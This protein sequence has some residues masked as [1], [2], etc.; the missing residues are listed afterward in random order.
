MSFIGCD[1]KRF[2][3]QLQERNIGLKGLYFRGKWRRELFVNTVAI[4]GSRR[5]TDY[6]RI[7]IGRLV[8]VLVEAGVTIISGFMYGV[9]REAH[10]VCLRCGGRTIAVLGWG[11]D[12]RVTDKE[13]RIYQDIIDKGGLVVSEYPGMTSAAIWTFPA[14][15]R[16]V[17]LAS[18]VTVVIEAAEKSGSLITAGLSSKFGRKVYAIPGSVSSKTSAGTNRLIKDGKAQMMTDPGEILRDLGI[19]P[20]TINSIGS[21]KAGEFTMVES[22]IKAALENGPMPIDLIIRVTCMP[23]NDIVSTVAMM[24]IKGLVRRVGNL[25]EL[26]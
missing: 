18:R 7:M 1:S 13:E 12:S 11:I 25:V 6:G 23:V 21:G 14:R 19:T 2:P 20:Y 22:G 15:N 17:A 8:P 4:V 3:A 26:V 24:E 10:E 9:D 5:M 16:I